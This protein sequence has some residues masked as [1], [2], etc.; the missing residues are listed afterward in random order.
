[1]RELVWYVRRHLLSILLGAS[2]VTTTAYSLP[3]EA[4]YGL[5][6]D[7]P[8]FA[9]DAQRSIEQGNARIA[10][11]MLARLA[12]AT[13]TSRELKWYYHVSCYAAVE[14]GSYQEA[15]SRCTRSIEHAATLWQD[16]ANRG[17][18]HAMIGN[19]DKAIADYQTAIRHSGNSSRL[20]RVIAALKKVRANPAPGE[21]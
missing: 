1:M 12:P 2:V 7:R 3:A 8:K 19:Y 5:Y 16:F 17:A 6:L 21:N 10:E 11:R 4:Q 15:I 20:T 9:K 14:Q 18:A 13:M